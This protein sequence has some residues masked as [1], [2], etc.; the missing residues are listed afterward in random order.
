MP[1]L[2]HSGPRKD[3]SVQSRDNKSDNTNVKAG[4]P[5]KD[6]SSGPFRPKMGPLCTVDEASGGGD[7]NIRYVKGGRQTAGD[8]GGRQ[9]GAAFAVD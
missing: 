6:A 3:T 7:H 2:I 8:L 5:G 1:P 4:L 9:Q